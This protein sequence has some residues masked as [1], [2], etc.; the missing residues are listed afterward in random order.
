MLGTDYPFIPGQIEGADAFISSAV[1]RG[2]LTADQA[3]AVLHANARAFI[4]KRGT[5]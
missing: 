2:A 5:R 4:E 1:E 3:G